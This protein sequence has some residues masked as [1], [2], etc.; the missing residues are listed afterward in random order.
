MTDLFPFSRHIHSNIYVCI[1]ARNQLFD[2]WKL[3]LIF[4]ELFSVAE[5]YSELYSL[6]LSCHS[7]SALQETR[8]THLNFISVRKHL[9]RSPR[10]RHEKCLLLEIHLYL[11]TFAYVQL[12]QQTYIHLY[13]YTYIYLGYLCHA[14]MP[15]RCGSQVNAARLWLNTHTQTHTHNYI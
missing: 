1:C 7:N 3:R 5:R 11:H 9:K 8:T 13:I 4:K 6:A 14:P 12:P 10:R 2:L 15:F